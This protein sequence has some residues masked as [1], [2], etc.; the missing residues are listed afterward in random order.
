VLPQTVGADN[1]PSIPLPRTVVSTVY[2]R[3]GGEVALDQSSP[4]NFTLR[5]SLF[6]LRLLGGQNAY[7]MLVGPDYRALPFRLSWMIEANSTGLWTPMVLVS[8]KLASLGNN[9]T[10]MFVVRTMRV[11][12]GSFTGTAKIFYWATSSGQIH[13][14]FEFDSGSLSH[15]RMQYY[16]SNLTDSVI[17]IPAVLP[18]ATSYSVTTGHANYTLS[19]SD[20]PSSFSPVASVSE[21]QLRLVFDVGT[22][23]A[24]DRATLDPSFIV[25]GLSDATAYSFQRHVFYDP[26]GG[27][28]WYFFLGGSNKPFQSALNY[29]YSPD[30]ASWY[31]SQKVPGLLNV[32]NDEGSIPDVF[33]AG[34]TVILAAGMENFTQVGYGEKVQVKFYTIQ[35]T[36]SGSHISWGQVNIQVFTVTQAC[37]TFACQVSGV[38]FANIGQSSDGSIVFSFNLFVRY[39]TCTQSTLY[40]EYKSFTKLITSAGPACSSS[41]FADQLR[42]IVLPS[43][44]QGSIRIVFQNST[45]NGFGGLVLESRTIDANG[46]LGSTE[47]VDSGGTPNSDEFSAVADASF[48]DHL[49]YRSNADGNVAYAYHA[50]GVTGWSNLAK[51]ILPPLSGSYVTY[52]SITFDYSMNKLYAFSLS[53]ENQGCG[54]A[55][56]V[57]RTKTLVGGWFDSS[58]TYPVDLQHTGISPIFFSSNYASASSTSS[59]TI[60]L[61]WTTGS[62]STY[63]ANFASIPLGSGWSPYSVP[64]D[65]WDGNGIAPYGQYFANLG[66]SVSSSTGMVTI[67][68]TDI[69]VPGRGLSFDIARVYTEPSGFWSGVYGYESYPWA[70]MGNGWQLNFPWM[71]NV[72]QPQYIHLWNGEGYKI[73]SSF[74]TTSGSGV[75]NNHFENHQGED[76]VLSNTLYNGVL[77]G[78]ELMTKSGVTYQFDAS[79]R[80][81]E[82]YDATPAHNTISFTYDS[83]NRIVAITDTVGRVFNINYY[84]SGD[85]VYQI[86]ERNSNGLSAVNWVTLGYTGQSLTSVADAL[87]RT[88]SFQYQAVSDPVAVSWLVSRIAYPT[89]WYTN[90]TY[91]PMF[92]GSEVTTFRVTKQ[93]V[94]FGP[95]SGTPVRQ[96]RYSYTP[97]AGGDVAESVVST[98]NSTQVVGYT[99]YAFAFAAVSWNVTDA[100]NNLLRGFV[101]QFGV[102][103]EPVKE[104]FIVTDRAGGSESPGSYTELYS[105]DLWGN[106]IY[107]RRVINPSTNWSHETFNGYY[108]DGLPPQFNLFQDSFSMNQETL[109]NNQWNIRGGLWTVQNGAPWNVANGVYNGTPVSGEQADMISSADVGVS[110]LKVTAKV[111]IGSQFNQ[112]YGVTPVVGLFDHYNQSA[113]KSYKWA[114]VLSN[115]GSITQLELL[116]EWNETIASTPPGYN[117][118]IVTGPIARG[119]WTLYLTTIGNEVSGYAVA[120]GVQGSCGATGYFHSS[121]PASKGTGFGVYAGGYSAL[122]ANVTVTPTTNYHFT[123]G[124]LGNFYPQGAPLSQV[125]GAIAGTAEDQNRTSVPIETYYNYTR[126]GGVNQVRQRCDSASGGW[127]LVSNSYDTYGHLIK[128]TD[129]RGNYTLYGYASPTYAN[130]YYSLLTTKN[131]TLLPGNTLLSTRFDYNF[132]SGEMTSQ[133]DPMGYRTTYTYDSLSRVTKVAYATGDHVS[134]TYNDA[135]NYV[136]VTN[137]NGWK[138]RQIYDGLGRL[139][140]VERFLNGKPYS[141]QTSTYNWL[142][143]SSSNIDAMGNVTSYGHDALGRLVNTT[144]ADGTRILEFYNDTGSW[145]LTRNQNGDYSC[146][147]SDR[148]G[149]LLTVIEAADSH[150]HPRLLSGFQY[151]TNYYY[152]E[153]GN[154]GRLVES[155]GQTTIYTYDNLNRLT[156]VGFTDKTFTS[157]SYDN[158]GN[159]VNSIDQNNIKTAYLYDSLNRPTNITYYGSRMERDNYTYDNNGNMIKMVSLNA[160]INRVLDPRGRLANEYYYVNPVTCTGC[161]GG[162]GGGGSVAEGTLITLANGT[163]VPVQSLQA[164][165][166]LLSYNVTSDIYTISTITRMDTVYTS[167]MLVIKTED[168][169]PL[170]VD[171]ATAQK[172]WMMKSDGSVGWFF[173]TEL[174]VG[175]YLFNAIEQRWTR[176]IEIGY[177][178]SGVHKMY[179]IYTTAPFDYIANNYLDP[180]K[181]PSGP[182]T[183]SG[184]VGASY[185]I[186]YSY[187]GENLATISYSP[188]FG[189]G[190]YYDGLGRVLNVSQGLPSYFAVFTYNKNDQITQ[191]TY[192]NGVTTGYSYDKLGRPAQITVGKTKNPLLSLAYTYNS[193]GTVASVI[194]SGVN[195]VN[196]NEQ[197]KYDAL[198][199]V[200]N[201]TVV[202]GA[203]TTRLWY[204]Y[205]TLGNRIMQGLNTTSVTLPSYKW[206]TTKYGYNAA[207]NELLNYTMSGNTI[208]YGYDANGNLFS[209]NITSA[210]QWTYKWDVPGHLLTASNTSAVQ[211]YYAYDADGRRVESKEGSTTTFF[212]YMGTETL[213]EQTQTGFLNN[214]VFADGMLIVKSS[215]SGI[216]YYHPD[217]LGSTRLTTDSSGKVVFADNYQ[218]FG[219]DNGTPSGSETY[220]F[221]GKPVSQTTGLYYEYQ[222]WYDPS[223]GRFISQDPLSGAASDPQSLNPYVYVQNTPTVL[224]DPTGACPQGGFWGFFCGGGTGSDSSDNTDTTRLGCSNAE[225]CSIRQRVCPQNPYICG[226][227]NWDQTDTAGT[228][229][230][231]EGIGGSASNPPTVTETVSDTATPRIAGTNPMAEAGSGVRMASPSASSEEL[232]ATGASYKFVSTPN[233]ELIRVPANWESRVANN[234]R[235]LVLQEPGASGNSNMIR[236]MDP[237]MR[238]PQGYVV[239][240]NEL[241]QPL[242]IY[243]QPTGPDATHIPLDYKGPIPGWP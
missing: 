151:V 171:N 222:R 216:T 73:P 95:G 185:E 114:A 54:A 135:Q 211:G 115:T 13:W 101:Q 242:D 6:A 4:D 105:Y 119:W 178:P 78:S 131:E 18:R 93:L 7:D 194:G 170:R 201:T 164:G 165:M 26:V 158:N 53:C 15:Y 162:G 140:T 134:Y 2:K 11:G 8:D 81:T 83:H 200:T 236:I 214:Y 130:Y 61:I 69:S 197:Y 225:E 127:T 29:T 76:F 217:A 233:G 25:T 84:S 128:Q 174:R 106:L 68:Q 223:T 212:A 113:A 141:N 188:T 91:T 143:Q 102:H 71:E 235:G 137:E 154:L 202:S 42:S 180:P 34:N 157:Y 40:A 207:N 122:F 149:R 192:G 50:P 62:P 160:T 75:Q 5:S 33:F 117:C 3:A 59:N 111:Y 179:D 32:P 107:S 145:T 176:V 48:G 28:F 88:T 14:D 74:W 20:V 19:W 27:N 85:L 41:P 104:T 219:Q 79:Q 138:T 43:N 45:S 190:Y 9:A 125:H 31:S 52:P 64:S 161:G 213:Y 112:T 80:L 182:S 72:S 98:Y 224:T 239:Y 168:P 99:L 226:G 227:A 92:H 87:G 199:R 118:Q 89:G 12:N 120:P 67:S 139:S 243:G 187:M 163:A 121:S 241:G 1:V 173:V 204:Q 132:S 35:G 90:Y 97:G 196:I 146:R 77:L 198:Q 49:V 175:D 30:G 231:T 100:S 23:R 56:I 109:P 153:V 126:W 44:S 155:N 36:V 144:Y 191:I 169:L 186:S 238:Y 193:T 17:N 183:P 110:D 189:I 159:I 181:V 229:P 37:T 55:S 24:G 136:D 70:P 167:N 16:W 116:D 177:A 205:D 96:Y 209:K 220:K 21:G 82:Y 206:I 108:N 150:C 38:R 124:Y 22:L 65:P 210:S 46:N 123:G 57:M 51:N 63:Q 230:S 228:P 240:Y 152:N 221:T 129:P 133:I 66:E 103:G 232:G 203:T 10:G 60:Q 184:V 215:S 234:G 47:T 166:Q 237:T 39:G 86:W 218:P 94:G 156:Q 58:V 195:G 172:L 142:D 148:L 147:I 208:R